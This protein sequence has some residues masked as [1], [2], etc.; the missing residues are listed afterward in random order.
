MGRGV[1]DRAFRTELAVFSIQF[2]AR[3]TDNCLL[4]TCLL[5]SALRALCVLY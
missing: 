3:E 5:L 2:S 1:G 4:T